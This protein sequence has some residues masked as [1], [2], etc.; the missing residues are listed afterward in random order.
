MG[1]LVG[2]FLSFEAAAA[3]HHIGDLAPVLRADPAQT[4][5]IVLQASQADLFIIGIGDRLAVQGDILEE[6]QI[7]VFG[8]LQRVQAAVGGLD[9][10]GAEPGKAELLADFDHE[11]VHA[12]RLAVGEGHLSRRHHGVT[13]GVGLGQPG[14]P[15][16]EFAP[17][18]V[19]HA[20]GDDV[21]GQPGRLIDKGVDSNNQG[22]GGL[23]I[24]KGLNQRVL[25]ARFTI[26]EVGVPADQRLERI[27]I[28]IDRAGDQPRLNGVGKRIPLILGRIGL[29]RGLIA[30]ELT[31]LFIGDAGTVDTDAGLLGFTGISR[32][33]VSGALHILELA[34][35]GTHPPLVVEAPHQGR[36]GQDGPGGVETGRVHGVAMAVNGH[37]AAVAGKLMG[38]LGNLLGRDTRLPGVLIQREAEGRF[39]EQGKG[40]LHRQLLALIDDRLIHLQ[41]GRIDLVRRL[42]LTIS[43]V[44]DQKV[45]LLG[46]IGGLEHTSFEGMARGDH[47]QMAGIGEARLAPPLHRGLAWHTEIG[48]VVPVVVDNPADHPH[49][50]GKVAAR[51]NRQPAGALTGGDAV[52]VGQHGGHGHVMQVAFAAC[53]GQ[54]FALALEGIARL[55]GG[56]T[57][58]DEILAVLKIRLEMRIFIE[59]AQ[60]GGVAGP[61]GE[62]ANGRVAREIFAAKGLQKAEDHEILAAFVGGPQNAQLVGDSAVFGVGRVD[63]R[64]QITDGR[65]TV[66]MPFA[67]EVA[68]TDYLLDELLGRDGDPFVLA[69]LARPLQRGEDPEFVVNLVEDDVAAGAGRRAVLQ[70]A[71]AV[72]RS[73]AQAVA[74]RSLIGEPGIAGQGMIGVAGRSHDRT[75]L[76][77]HF[78]SYPALGRAPDTHGAGH[79]EI[80][81]GF[82]LAIRVDVS[83]GR[84]GIAVDGVGRRVAPPAQ[85]RRGRQGVTITYSGA[86]RRGQSRDF[87]KL[88][89]ALFHDSSSFP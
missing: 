57:E 59:V 30:L 56:G 70:A 43:A 9:G 61:H 73:P 72:V 13:Y 17:G 44:Y 78:D 2:P 77:I 80:G 64:L 5:H 12:H 36:Q 8:A 53:P 26:D 68:A 47:H 87:E 62:A 67:K 1:P 38:Q 25:P 51:T 24:F 39:L 46:L 6:T 81:I 63:G 66:Y 37:F 48:A 23:G 20:V 33:I 3:G 10:L 32:E 55:P 40:R 83:F 49:G 88:P 58:V 19:E 7:E 79:G 31:G 74:Q 71:F 16:V 27:G 69:A 29:A 42:E 76:V 54:E 21:I 52:A 75:A 18:F 85:A 45:L 89:S 82:H 50:Q 41:A 65:Q 11:T 28:T 86:G 14:P 35:A 60:K 22:D 84:G 4:R 15:G 34:A